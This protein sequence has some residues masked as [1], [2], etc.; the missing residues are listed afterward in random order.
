MRAHFRFPFPNSTKKNTATTF[1]SADW[2]PPSS[3]SAISF[4]TKVSSRR[5][6]ICA[7]RFRT[8][9]AAR[10]RRAFSARSKTRGLRPSSQAGESPPIRTCARCSPNGAT[11][12][13][14]FRRSNSAAT[15]ARWSQASPIIFCSAAIRVRLILQLRL[16]FL[17]SSADWNR[18]GGDSDKAAMTICTAS[19]CSAKRGEKTN[20]R[21]R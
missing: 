18:C 3:I 4:W 5:R 11:S 8:L 6:K 20:G 2:K 12:R 1:R 14:Y 17:S 19:L 16:V 15:T 9:H 7:L 10:S 21:S 13:A